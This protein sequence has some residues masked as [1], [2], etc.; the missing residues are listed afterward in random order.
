MRTGVIT[1]NWRKP[2]TGSVPHVHNNS[3]EY[4]IRFRRGRSLPPSRLRIC[5]SIYYTCIPWLGEVSGP[6]SS[7]QGQ[8]TIAVNSIRMGIFK[9]SH[10]WA[11]YEDVDISTQFQTKQKKNS[12]KLHLLPHTLFSVRW[13]SPPTITWV[14]GDW[15]VADTAGE[16]E[17]EWTVGSQ[18]KC[19]RSVRLTILPLFSLQPQEATLSDSGLI[20][21]C[22]IMTT[23]SHSVAVYLRVCLSVCPGGGYG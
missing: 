22:L 9:S 18:R 17:I 13:S 20:V 23:H 4:C 11:E 8:K 1:F 6:P 21:G 3:H 7:G 19:S 15:S 10:C 14:G 12:R 5:L 2:G 16:M